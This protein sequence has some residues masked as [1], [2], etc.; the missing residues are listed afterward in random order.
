MDSQVSTAVC[1]HH[2][3][4]L[5]EQQHIPKIT[6]SKLPLFGIF[7]SESLRE[8]D[9]TKTLTKVEEEASDSTYLYSVAFLPGMVRRRGTLRLQ[10]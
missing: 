8:E 4:V 3:A 5:Q 2:A 6:F 1:T 10:G 7:C 9:K